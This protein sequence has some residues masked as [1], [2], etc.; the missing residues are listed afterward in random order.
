VLVR[1]IQGEVGSVPVQPGDADG[2]RT[3]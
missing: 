3:A 2:W 1:V